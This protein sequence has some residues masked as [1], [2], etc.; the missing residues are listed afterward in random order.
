MD[1]CICC[2][3]KLENGF[4]ASKFCSSCSVYHKELKDKIN[5]L[6]NRLERWMGRYNKLKSKLTEK[7][8]DVL[9]NATSKF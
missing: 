8:E 2:G 3:K 5:V 4:A 1:N 7:Q 9:E 6:E